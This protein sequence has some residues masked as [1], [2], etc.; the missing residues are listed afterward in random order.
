MTT[1]IQSQT[2]PIEQVEV[3]EVQKE[4]T[5]VQLALEATN[6]LKEVDNSDIKTFSEYSFEYTSESGARTIYLR[7][8][9]KTLLTMRILAKVESINLDPQYKSYSGSTILYI[10]S[11][12]MA[13][14]VLDSQGEISSRGAI[15]K[16]L[17]IDEILDMNVENFEL[18]SKF[19]E[20]ILEVNYIMTELSS[21][22]G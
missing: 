2:N 20:T 3:N 4:I 13:M 19:V 6:K 5:D 16:P 11:V 17:N 7:F 21:K 14:Q 1:R 22:S 8:K 10:C 9:K 18:F 15:F 12:I